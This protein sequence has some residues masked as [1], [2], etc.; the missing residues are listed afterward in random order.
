MKIQIEELKASNLELQAFK[1]RTLRA[2]RRG[3]GLLSPKPGPSPDF[4]NDA[5]QGSGFAP[6]DSARQLLSDDAKIA[7]MS[8]LN[9]CLPGL[10]KDFLNDLTMSANTDFDSTYAMADMRIRE[11]PPSNPE[12]GSVGCE[13]WEA[14]QPSNDYSLRSRDSM[15]H[16]AVLHLDS[17]DN[18]DDLINSSPD[19]TT[20]G[21]SS[22]GRG[23]TGVEKEPA[24]SKRRPSSAAAS[25]ARSDCSDKSQRAM[26]V[27]VANR[28]TAVVKLL[29][30]HGVDVNAQDESR[31]TVL[32]DATEANDAK[33]VQLLLQHG[34]D[35]NAVDL[36]GMTAL[37][38]AA[39]LG[40]IEVAEVLLKEGAD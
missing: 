26:K 34:A 33:T 12:S 37:E 38:L 11:Y 31:R 19:Q 9:T 24:I 8:T 23:I 10:E 35:S 15:G 40:N 21:Q 6:Q 4:S 1:E 13:A 29:I 5:C 22:R 39:A 30:S 3:S 14:L 25:I 16:V 18:F 20:L 27:A 36:S 32:H 7:P 17:S 2:S 28:Q